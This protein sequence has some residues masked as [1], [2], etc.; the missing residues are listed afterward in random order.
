MRL[1]C[2]GA[3]RLLVRIVRIEGGAAHIRPGANVLDG[4]R[5]VAP[6]RISAMSAS[7]SEARVRATRRSIWRFSFSRSIFT[8]RPLSAARFRTGSACVC[9]NRVSGQAVSNAMPCP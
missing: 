4:N 6:L 7:C 8:D 5:G 3:Q 2:R 9:G 1:D